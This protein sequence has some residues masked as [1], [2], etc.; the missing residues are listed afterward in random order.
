MRFRAGFFV[1]ACGLIAAYPTGSAADTVA[2]HRLQAPEAT[3]KGGVFVEDFYDGVLLFGVIKTHGIPT[4]YRFQ[5]GRTKAYGH[6]AYVGEDAYGYDGKFPVEVEGLTNYLSPDTTY[7][8]RMIVWNKAGK[9]VSRDRT[10]H[11][12]SA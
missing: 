1:I 7:H 8:F 4:H 3:T 12:P 6:R 9:S 11:T 2:S 5:Y 10:F